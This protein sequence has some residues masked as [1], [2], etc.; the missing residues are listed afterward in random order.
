VR[1]SHLKLTFR[2]PRPDASQYSDDA[3]SH[4]ISRA[5]RPHVRADHACSSRNLGALGHE[6]RVVESH[7]PAAGFSLRRLSLTLPDVPHGVSVKEFGAKGDGVTDDTPAFLAAPARA[8]LW[9][10][11]I[12]FAVCVRPD[13]GSGKIACM[14]RTASHPCG[15]SK[16]F[17]TGRKN[18][19]VYPGEY[20]IQTGRDIC[21]SPAEPARHRLMPTGMTAKTRPGQPVAYFLMLQKTR[22]WRSKA[23]ISLNFAPLPQP[24]GS[25][26]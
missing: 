4:K 24:A 12:R 21:S 6:R 17:C 23:S 14:P 1:K 11:I 20:K 8:K 3:R 15:R 18:T 9:N 2:C 13:P 7:Q 5:A 25:G 19:P 22:S 10:Q 26:C 16:G